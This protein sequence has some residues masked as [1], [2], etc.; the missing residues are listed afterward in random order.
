SYSNAKRRAA[1]RLGI[2]YRSVEYGSETVEEKIVNDIAALNAEDGVDGIIVQTP[3]PSHIRE[4]SLLNAIDEFRDV[5]C[6]GDKCRGKLYSGHPIYVP[7]TAS[8][9]VEILRRGG[10]E[11]A[12]KHV[13][14]LGRGYNAGMPLAVL[15]LRKGEGDATVTVCHSKTRDLSKYTLSADILICAVGKAGILTAEM[16]RPGAVIVDVGINSI[17]DENAPGGYRITGDAAPDV[18]EVAGAI[19]PVPGGVGPVTVACLMFN[20]ANAFISR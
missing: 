13:V 7:A 3:L 15:L 2:E 9:V 20:V 14:I 16:V 19:T 17:R 10:Y 11:T 6:G 12:G 4:A 1:G 8:A 18:A 5:D